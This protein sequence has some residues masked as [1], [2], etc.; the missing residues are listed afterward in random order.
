M[1]ELDKNFKLTES[2]CA[3][4]GCRETVR[5]IRA[6]P[7]RRCPVCVEREFKREEKAREQAAK[8]REDEKLRELREKLAEQLAKAG[9]PPRYARRTRAAWE[10][11]YRPWKLSRLRSLG[12]EEMTIE[13]ISRAWIDQAD[14]ERDWLLILLGPVGTRKTSL[15]TAILGEALA[16]GHGCVWADFESWSDRMEAGILAPPMHQKGWEHW[17]QPFRAA[18][19]AERVLLD[20]VGAVRGERGSKSGRFWRERFAQAIRE[21][22]MWLRPT[23]VTS[24]LLTIEDFTRMSGSLPSRMSVRLAFH[25]VSDDHRRR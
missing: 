22:E 15:A 20:D 12:G 25:L 11:K 8:D 2:P 6:V 13:E 3:T 14:D 21:R 5:G 23:I 19:D 7:G 24:N 4:P 9:A 17:F 16:A 18:V 1:G 10:A